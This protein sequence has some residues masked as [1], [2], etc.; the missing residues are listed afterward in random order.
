MDTENRES[1]RRDI[2][3]TM[4]RSVCVFQR[5]DSSFEWHW[6]YCYCRAL[7]CG[8]LLFSKMQLLLSWKERCVECHNAETQKGELNLS[9]PERI[10][11]GSESGPVIKSGDPGHSHLFEMVERGEMPKKGKR[12]NE[13]ELKLLPRLDQRR[14][15]VSQG[16]DA[17]EKCATPA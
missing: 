6:L 17:N 7:P 5:A 13:T 8:R 16:S 15:E 3:G 9:S 12:L 11:E 10:A 4:R 2:F 1:P 14:R